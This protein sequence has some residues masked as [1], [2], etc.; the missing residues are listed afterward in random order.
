MTQ[1]PVPQHK[2]WA[3]TSWILDHPVHET[4][5]AS[6]RQRNTLIPI[7]TGRFLVS[8]ALLIAG[9]S[10]LESEL[11]KQR[12]YIAFVMRGLNDICDAPYALELHTQ[13]P[14]WM[15]FNK[16]ATED[17]Q[18]QAVRSW[19]PDFQWIAPKL[20][21]K[22]PWAELIPHLYNLEAILVDGRA[23]VYDDALIAGLQT[24]CSGAQDS[25]HIPANPLNFTLTAREGTE[26]FGIPARF[27]NARREAACKRFWVLPMFLKDVAHW[28]VGIFNHGTNVLYWKNSMKD[29]AD[30]NYQAVMMDYVS[31]SLGYSVHCTVVEITPGF[32]QPDDSSCGLW[33]LETTR[34]FF[35]SL[36]RGDFPGCLSNGKF[37]RNDREFY[38]GMSRE[39]IKSNVVLLQRMRGAWL[40][41]LRNIF[42]H[43]PKCPLQASY[44]D[45]VSRSDA[46][47]VSYTEVQS[48]LRRNGEQGMKL[49]RVRGTASPQVRTPSS[50][51][52]QRDYTPRQRTD[53]TRENPQSL[54][55]SPDSDVAIITTGLRSLSVSPLAIT[56]EVM[57][58]NGQ[59]IQRISRPRLTGALQSPTIHP[60]WSGWKD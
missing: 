36:H 54:L 33:V 60:T 32:V 1:P 50:S 57:D 12:P 47:M 23:W 14:Q 26:I 20:A 37:F 39:A 7:H 28:A 6:Q 22:R 4:S 27:R 21:W 3:K 42:Y 2:L 24:L 58:E 17:Q 40:T 34:L 46:F 16:L 55:S 45:R 53:G 29:M 18:I 48:R 9:R 59:R 56:R 5:Q 35:A 13:R 19:F 51:F 38:S 49:R 41:F 15:L 30:Y 31:Y 52:R 44:V 8:P 10:L 25:V 11:K 43:K